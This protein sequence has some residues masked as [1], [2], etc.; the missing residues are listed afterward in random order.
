MPIV[1]GCRSISCAARAA[2]PPRIDGLLRCASCTR[3]SRRSPACPGCSPSPRPRSAS[4]VRAS[5]AFSPASSRR[6]RAIAPRSRDEVTR[7]ATRSRLKLLAAAC[8]DHA[9]RLRALLAPLGAEAPA[10]APELYSALG[11]TVPAGQGLTSYYAN[12]H[13]DWSW[14]EPRT[15]RRSASSTPRLAQAPPG[16]TLLLGVGAGRL[17]YDLHRATPR[18]ALRRG[19]PQPAVPAR[20]A[21]AVCRRGARALRVPGRAARHRRARRSCAACRRPAPAR[22]DCTSCSPTR[23]ARRLRRARS[24]PSSRPGSSTSRRG[25]RVFAR[26]VNGWL[27]PGGRWVN[28]RL[29]GVRR[30]RARAA[31]RARGGAARSSRRRA[32]PAS[33]RRGRRCPTCARRRAATAASSRS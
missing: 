7:A 28:T 10:S 18:R 24:T 33:S 5:T 9:R 8:T 1:P 6:P 13:R 23:R 19:R 16:R 3:S 4:G 17:A 2:G 21:A 22:P 26:R 27:R 32:L 20:R 25:L 30:R 29:A 31:L 15:R 11:M 14:G 12:L